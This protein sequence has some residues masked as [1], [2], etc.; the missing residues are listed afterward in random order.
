[1]AGTKKR[2]DRKVFFEQLELFIEGRTTVAK[3]AEEI[4]VSVPTLKPRWEHWLRT[5]EA[6][7]EWFIQKDERKTKKHT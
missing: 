4:G 2:V 3:A 6:K 5:R 7:E 1:M